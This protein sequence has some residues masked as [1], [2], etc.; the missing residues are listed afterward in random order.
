MGSDSECPLFN[1]AS[2]TLVMCGYRD[3]H[4]LQTL[5]L[6]STDLYARILHASTTWKRMHDV[7]P[8]LTGLCMTRA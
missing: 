3:S 7:L 5:S 6:S 1:F 4:I 2:Q 8:V